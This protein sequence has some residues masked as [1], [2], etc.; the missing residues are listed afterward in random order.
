LKDALEEVRQTVKTLL[1]KKREKEPDQEVAGPAPEAGP[2]PE[3]EVEA[4]G[5][6]LATAGGAAAAPARARVRA[7]GLA[8]EPVDREDAIARVVGAAKFLRAQDACS[9]ASYLLLRGL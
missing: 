6:Q 1:Q 9:P 4:A 7:G 2:E 3:Q 8:P 5:P